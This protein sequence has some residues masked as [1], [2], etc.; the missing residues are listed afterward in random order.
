MV[1][2]GISTASGIVAASISSRAVVGR[3]GIPVLT[4]R[5]KSIM[6]CLSAIQ[7]SKI[8]RTKLK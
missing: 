6:L 5:K 1:V 7:E 4:S 3:G 8:G 2:T